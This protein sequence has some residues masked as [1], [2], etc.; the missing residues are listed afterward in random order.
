MA[1]SFTRPPRIKG[2]G[3]MPVKAAHMDQLGR[4]IEELQNAIRATG[5]KS[6]PFVPS[7]LQPFWTSITQVPSSDPPEYQVTVTQ[8]YLTYQNAG[9]SESELGVTGYIVPKIAGVAMDNEE[10]E[11]LPLPG[12]V[13]FVYLRVKTDADGVPKFDGESVT[14]EAFEEAQ[15][16]IHHVR[17]SPSGGE[18][19]GDYFFLILQTEG[20]GGTPEK[21]RAVRRLTGNRELPN[22]LV[23]IANIGGKREIYKGYTAGPDDKHEVR[24]LEQLEGEGEPIIKPLGEG[25]EEGDT[26]PFKMI[27]EGERHQVTVRTN[28]GGDAVVVEGNGTGVLTY[29]DGFDGQISFDDGLVT[30]ITPPTEG[31]NFNIV[32][33]TYTYLIDFPGENITGPNYES[34]QYLYVRNGRV[35]RT[36]PDDDVAA[37]FPIAISFYLSS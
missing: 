6:S 27:A 37:I 33:T 11:P 13:S 23:E 12:V 28:A 14:I 35:T 25:E 29:A 30:S 32:I 26:L 21:P 15:Q 16:S 8:G 9:A 36:D 17:P 10:V 7:K 34:A 1:N 5:G 3:T 24:S 18:E 22:Q 2:G 31:D 4:C 19:E 20:D